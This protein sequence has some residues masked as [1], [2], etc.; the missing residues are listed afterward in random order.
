MGFRTPVSAAA[1]AAAY[2]AVL[3]QW[4]VPVDA[5]DVPT[6]YG[7]TRVHVC[8]T[9]DGTPLVLL[10]GGGATS[11]AWFANVAEL[12]KHHRIHAVDLLGDAGRSVAD[13]KAIGGVGD[14]MA[15]QDE[16]F[17][18][19]G[20][21]NAHL[22]GHSYGAWIALHYAIHSPRVHSLALLDPT[23]CFTR[24]N[25]RYLLRALPMLLRP[26]PRRTR[27]FLL[28]EAGGTGIDPALL[29]LQA[30]GAEFKT[31]KVITRP[32]PDP[33]RLTVPMLVLAAG[34]SKA[35]NPDRLIAQARRLVPDVQT[36]VLPGVGH[37]ALP[38]ENA[39]RLNEILADFFARVRP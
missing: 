34:K 11:T 39:A 21:E 8:G 2:D 12:G 29:E 20:V 28:W 23:G 17:D 7:T 13:G 9:P 19:L 16:L 30:R 15:W 26:T 22:C 3:A 36:A 10:H 35:H 38:T 31:A 32:N 14:L 1:F 25:P 24:W 27:D 5:L 4:P 33:S 18:H 37:H 6:A